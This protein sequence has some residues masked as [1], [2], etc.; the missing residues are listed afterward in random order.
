MGAASFTMIGSLFFS[1]QSDCD[2][3]DCE[4]ATGDCSDSRHT[5]ESFKITEIVSP[6]SSSVALSELTS[7]GNVVIKGSSLTLTREAYLVDSQGTRY[8]ISLNK[9]YITDDKII[10]SLKSAADE[11][12]TQSLVLV[13]EFGCTA[14]YQIGKPVSAPEISRF[15][16]EFVPDGGVLR[17]AG[18]NFRE[19]LPA[20]DTLKVWFEEANILTGTPNGKRYAVARNNV[21]IANNGKELL[22]TIPSG[23]PNST[24]LAVSNSQGTAY[25]SMFFRDTRNVWL[26][27]DSEETSAGDENGALQAYNS[28]TNNSG[29]RAWRT[30]EA[31]SGTDYSIILT[32]I[33]GSF[34]AGCGNDVDSRANQYGVLAT[35]QGQ[36]YF[37]KSGY[38]Y[39]APYSM[40][41]AEKDLLGI[42]KNRD[43]ND[44]VL[45]FEVYVSPELP[46][47][48][49]AYLVFSAYGCDATDENTRI[50]YLEKY[51]DLDIDNDI[52]PGRFSRDLT[53][54]TRLKLGQNRRS[55]DG[56]SFVCNVACG[57][58]GAWFHPGSAEVI[59]E[60]GCINSANPFSTEGWMTVSIPLTSGD[61]GN[62]AY[63]IS[64]YGFPCSYSKGKHC[65]PLNKTDFCNFYIEVEDI[66][67]QKKAGEGN[68]MFL[69]VDNFRIVPEDNGGTRFSKYDG[70]IESSKYP[71]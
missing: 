26:D 28:S 18:A 54:N 39:Y 52:I 25:S 27:F 6:D 2:C 15:Y 44:L 9:N 70:A 38:I 4:C 22:I 56:E 62:F 47:Y 65:G 16:C 13:S 41:L 7:I 3:P 36:G 8:V 33:G 31:L 12:P 20:K 23:I 32:R 48:S 14:E 35:S 55:D 19:S 63:N 45:K 53:S 69:A 40:G 21:K 37:N 67:L 59:E 10:V 66:D 60:M 46:W 64:N 51:Y 57:T 24:K 42:F 58:P 43:L 5:C 61:G 1:C 50:S 30:S 29:K 17:V 49:Y 71:Y 68:L 34:P 11:I